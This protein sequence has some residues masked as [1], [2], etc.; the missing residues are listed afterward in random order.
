[1]KNVITKLG[2]PTDY[3]LTEMIAENARRSNDNFMSIRR[4]HNTLVVGFVVLDIL[5]LVGNAVM[6][7]RIDKLEGRILELEH[8]K[9]TENF[10]AEMEK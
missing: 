3:T 5:F 9:E 8:A 1:M 10:E 7:D 2:V 4:A 6:H